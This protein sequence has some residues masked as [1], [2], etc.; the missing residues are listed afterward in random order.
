MVCAQPR[1]LG[2]ALALI[3]HPVHLYKY[4]ARSHSLCF[5]FF[6][7][8]SIYL[9]GRMLLSSPRDH[10]RKNSPLFLFDRLINLTTLTDIFLDIRCLYSS[11]L[12]DSFVI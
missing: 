11:A 9:P 3:Q 8:E 6:T 5:P 4:L 12:S 7:D 10:H 2:P 1:E